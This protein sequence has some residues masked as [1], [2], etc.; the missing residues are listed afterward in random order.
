MKF[1]GIWTNHP[2]EITSVSFV[3]D[4]PILITTDS[5]P[6]IIMWHTKN[7]IGSG[8]EQNTVYNRNL[9]Y[10]M[11][12]L[13]KV[14]LGELSISST[15]D[16]ITKL[17]NSE[18]IE[19]EFNHNDRYTISYINRYLEEMTPEDA[20]NESLE[21]ADDDG[22]PP[23]YLNEDVVLDTTEPEPTPQEV[24]TRRIT[25]DD[26]YLMHFCDDF[27]Y[28]YMLELNWLINSLSIEQSNETCKGICIE[29]FNLFV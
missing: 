8:Y 17:S 6:W 21:T 5:E 16:S 2:Y 26:A 15:C 18:L 25:W 11:I 9:N 22:P 4:Y 13:M 14:E 3:P 19:T 28:M 10:Q 23:K 29:L 1:I 12:R 27:G 20:K 24:R 7:R